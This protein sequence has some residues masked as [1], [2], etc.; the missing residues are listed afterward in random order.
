MYYKQQKDCTCGP[1]ALRNALSNLGFKYSEEYLANLLK[2]NDARGTWSYN[3]KK[4]IGKI[5]IISIEKENISLREIKLL[6]K[7]GFQVITCFFIEDEKV[8]HYTVVREITDIALILQDPWYGNQH[9]IKKN[10]FKDNWFLDPKFENRKKWI[11]A[12]KNIPNPK[13]SLLFI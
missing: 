12:I 10:K 7:K 4:A 3:F 8:D 6:Q 1:S 9:R 11:F 2:T 13:A 5:P